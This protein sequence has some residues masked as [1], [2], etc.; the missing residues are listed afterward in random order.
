MTEEINTS[1]GGRLGLTLLRRKN[2]APCSMAVSEEDRHTSHSS[3]SSNCSDH[4][5]H[6]DD[7]LTTVDSFGEGSHSTTTTTSTTVS[8]SST[9]GDIDFFTVDHGG[10]MLVTSPTRA[11]SSSYSTSRRLAW[12]SKKSPPKP[13]ATRLQRQWCMN[14][15]LNLCQGSCRKLDCPMAE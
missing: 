1:G 11:S 15:Q 13:P 9:V 4:S 10:A 12:P 5:T 6:N 3:S 2:R 14:N 8:S 7:K